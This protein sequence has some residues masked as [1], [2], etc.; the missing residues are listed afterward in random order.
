MGNPAVL[1]VEQAGNPAGR[2]REAEATRIR[3][4]VEDQPD[5]YRDRS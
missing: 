3:Q 1:R 5:S 2:I 4:V